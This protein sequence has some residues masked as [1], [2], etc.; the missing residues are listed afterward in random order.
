MARFSAQ[1]SEWYNPTGPYALLHKMNPI[2]TQFIRQHLELFNPLSTPSKPFKGLNILDIG[3]GG[4]FLSNSLHR[5]GANVTGVDANYDNIQTAKQ[6]NPQINFL[7]SKIEDLQTEFDVV[8]GLEILEHVTDPSAFVNEC[9]R[10]TKPGGMLFFS[11]INR[12][13]KSYLGTIFIAEGLG[14]VPKGTHTYEKYITPDELNE[15]CGG[16]VELKGMEYIPGCGFKLTNDTS[17]NYIAA[18]K[19]E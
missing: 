3:C 11:T 14:W 19:K 17:M 6:Y 1:A 13:L 18:V 9:F 12:N 8:V 5:L 15:M 7:H 2:R 4:G 10:V 16:L